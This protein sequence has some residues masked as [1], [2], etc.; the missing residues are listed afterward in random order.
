MFRLAMPALILAAGLLTGGAADQRSDARAQAKLDRTLHGLTPGKPQDCITRERMY[1]PR[2][3]PDTILYVEGRN[4]V[5][6]N[7]TVGTCAGL[8]RDDLVVITS[9]SGRV[10]A[11]DLV[12]TRSRI[13]GGFTGSCALGKFVPYT[14]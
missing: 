12:Q 11:G 9:V 3:F 13:G 7:D 8:A 4:R 10:C 2:Y 14:K 1:Q 5:W 6:R